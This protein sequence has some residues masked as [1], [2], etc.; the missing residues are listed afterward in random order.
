MPQGNLLRAATSDRAEDIVLLVSSGIASALLAV[1]YSR[2]LHEQYHA[3][4]VGAAVLVTGLL[5]VTTELPADV[6]LFGAFP[7]LLTLSLLASRVY[8]GR[9][10]GSKA[11]PAS[12]LDAKET[13]R[14]RS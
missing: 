8:D 12:G 4:L 9:L 13:G 7:W 1:A 14:E 3:E 2:G 10:K 11:H 6:V 5:L